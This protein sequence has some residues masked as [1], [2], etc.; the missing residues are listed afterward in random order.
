MRSTN[1][2]LQYIEANVRPGEALPTEQR[3]SDLCEVSRSAIRHALGYL[4]TRGVISV[5]ERRLLRKPVQDDYFDVA[6]LQ[7]GAERIQQVLLE[8]VYQSDLPP[9]S[10]FSETELARAAGAS[11]VSVREFLIGFS[12]F[13]LIEKKLRGGWRL[14]AFDHAYATELAD[15]RRMFEFAAVEQFCALAPDDPAAAQ[16]DDLIARHEQLDSAMPE[17]HK[18][19]P[20]LDRDFHTYLIGL[21]D[22]RFAR[23]FYD[24]ISLVFHY[25]Y[26]WDKGTE[27]VRN[28]YA[29]Q[30]HLAILRALA[31]RDTQAALAAMRTHLDSSRRTM[32]QSIRIRENKTHPG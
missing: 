17:R 24:I 18:D 25:H 13:G 27:Q 14:C 12:R 3:M 19:F 31:T 16:L 30:E 26:Q 5:K 10:E 8:R 1:L 9:G 23:S 22:N 15:T 6:E 28:Q 7:T 32:L 29:V 2:L 21:L 11:T 20:A 4:D